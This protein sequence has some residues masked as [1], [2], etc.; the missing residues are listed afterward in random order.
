[1]GLLVG[2]EQEV[3][4]WLEN[5]ANEHNKDILRDVDSMEDFMPETA[6]GQWC[7]S[8][9]SSSCAHSCHSGGVATTGAEFGG[10]GYAGFYNSNGCGGDCCQGVD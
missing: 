5:M 8:S 2:T 1:M 3:S 10:G 4:S 6:D 9:C 7:L